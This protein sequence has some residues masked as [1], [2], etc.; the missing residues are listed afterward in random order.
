MV[1]V[2]QYA[3]DQDGHR[4]APAASARHH[5]RRESEGQRGV[6]AGLRHLA[7]R[8]RVASNPRPD[9]A[10]AG[11]RAAR[12]GCGTR[13]GS[14]GGGVRID[15][16][17]VRRGAVDRDRQ[18]FAAGVLAALPELGNALGEWLVATVGVRHPLVAEFDHPIDGRRV[19]TPEQHGRPRLLDGLRPR[20]DTIEVDVLAVEG[21]LFGRPDRLHGLASAR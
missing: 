5:Q 20:P 16:V 18:P 17:R 13:S 1:G 21:G 8:S 12:R 10:Q 2:D 11:Q 14:P 9:P 3:R 15:Q 6:V 19:V 7:T 4:R